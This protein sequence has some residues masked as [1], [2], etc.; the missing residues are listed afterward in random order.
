MRRERCC[1]LSILVVTECAFGYANHNGELLNRVAVLLAEFSQS[2]SKHL[3]A[4]VF[5]LFNHRNSPYIV[6][7]KTIFVELQIIY[8]KQLDRLIVEW[9][10]HITANDSHLLHLA[11]TTVAVS[12]R[13]FISERKIF[14]FSFAILLLFWK[15]GF[16]CDNLR[17]ILDNLV[18]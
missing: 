3:F 6:I 8:H 18:L 14:L 2:F 9:Y 4:G 12:Q 15:G 5:C 13:S 17:T 1:F 10:N 7:K 11:T 16:T